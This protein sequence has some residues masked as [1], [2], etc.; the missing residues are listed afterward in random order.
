MHDGSF[1]L[2]SATNNGK[3]YTVFTNE[4]TLSL[5]GKWFNIDFL[6]RAVSFIGGTPKNKMVKHVILESRLSFLSMRKNK[7]SY[8]S[9]L[10]SLIPSDYTPV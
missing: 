1:W 2:A 4:E 9:G 6:D 10:P 7:D 5:S 3:L 8:F